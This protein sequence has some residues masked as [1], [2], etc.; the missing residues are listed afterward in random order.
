MKPYLLVWGI[1]L[2]LYLLLPTGSIQVNINYVKEEPTSFY[3]GAF[4]LVL[5]G[6]GSF[7]GERLF[8]PKSHTI[9]CK[10]KGIYFGWV[11]LTA[12]LGLLGYMVWFWRLLVDPQPLIDIF[13][14]KSTTVRGI[15]STIPGLTTLSQLGVVFSIFYAYNRFFARIAMPTRFNAYLGMLFILTLIRSFAWNE[16]LALVEFLAPLIL[17]YIS[18]RKFGGFA[19]IFLVFAPFLGLI[20]LVLFFGLFEAF[21]S[22]QAYT[23]ISDGGLLAYSVFRLL[24][25]YFTAVNN[26]IGYWTLLEA[27]SLKFEYVLSWAYLFPIGGNHLSDALNVNYDTYRQFL[28][29]YLNP[30]FTNATGIFPI[31]WDFGITLGL[32]YA[33]TLGLIIGALFIS[34]RYGGRWG[35]LYPTAYFALIEMLR[36][37]YLHETRVLPIICFL[38]LG[39]VIIRIR[40]SFKRLRSSGVAE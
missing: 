4:F 23:E 29:T 2:P 25:Y 19:R 37:T 5:L 34:Y 35:L 26:G 3:L 1:L 22:W 11:E 38:T 24:A 28:V 20:L 36:I 7:L 10:T 15:I 6:L 39:V 12:L 33:F 30:E 14:G 8:V 17:L 9:L 31:F 40:H 16:R 21:R 18:G 32:V 13:T 27:P